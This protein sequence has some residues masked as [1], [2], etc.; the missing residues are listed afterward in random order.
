MRRIRAGGDWGEDLYLPHTEY[1]H[2]PSVPADTYRS[3]AASMGLGTL[4]QSGGLR[5]SQLSD[6]DGTV[7]EE[8][9]PGASKKQLNL[10]WSSHS[11][12]HLFHADTRMLAG[13]DAGADAIA[14]SHGANS[15]PAPDTSQTEVGKA[16]PA[17]TTVNSQAESC[18]R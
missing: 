9:A 15:T 14:A 17:P 7:V 16:S 11:Q 18:S 6:A 13:T 8:A 4:I 2:G 10:R 5:T 3:P 1:L 12:Y